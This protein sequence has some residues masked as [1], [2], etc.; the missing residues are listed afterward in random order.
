MLNGVSLGVCAEQASN[1]AT[2]QD[3]RPSQISRA[4]GQVLGREKPA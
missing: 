1:S 3:A 4:A 2:N